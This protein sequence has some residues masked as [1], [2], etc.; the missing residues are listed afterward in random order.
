MRVAA[1]RQRQRPIPASVP[2]QTEASFT[3]PLFTPP[4]Q[5]FFTVDNGF[6]F[7][8]G[9]TMAPGG[10]EIY[11][12][13]AIPGWTN[14][15]LALSLLRGVAFKM[16]L[17]ADGRSTVGSAARGAEDHQPLPRPRRPPR[18]HAYLHR[19]RRVRPHQR[20]HRGADDER[21]QPGSILEF[22]FAGT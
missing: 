1:G 16:T 3:N 19:D 22:T 12:G 5:T 17:A 15:I 6:D 11:T 20:R 14:S 18:R 8:Q 7:R 21:R 4:L 13:K 2:Q 10:L 9:A